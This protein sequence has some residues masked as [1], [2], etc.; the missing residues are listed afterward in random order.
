MALVANSKMLPYQFLPNAM[1]WTPATNN[2][3]HLDFIPM[4][5][6]SHRTIA[7]THGDDAFE[8]QADRA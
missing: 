4:V 6:N 7:Q 8:Q 3:N 1:Q 5:R 2:I